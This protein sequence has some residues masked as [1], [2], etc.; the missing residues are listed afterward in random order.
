MRQ[1]GDR[2][3]IFVECKSM[4]HWFLAFGHTDTVHVRGW[5]EHWAGTEREIPFSAT[6]VD[7]AVWGRGAGEPESRN[8][9]HA[10]SREGTQA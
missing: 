4:R 1:T 10:G 9:H 7:A 6:I 3:W 2:D 5:S 8:R